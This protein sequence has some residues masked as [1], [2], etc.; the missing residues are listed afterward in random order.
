MRHTQSYFVIMVYGVII[1]MW[2]KWVCGVNR[3]ENF[4]V[5]VLCDMSL[6]CW[7]CLYVKSN[8]DKW[9]YSLIS[10][11]YH[12]ITYLITYFS[13]CWPRIFTMEPINWF[14]M[15]SCCVCDCCKESIN[16]V[17]FSPCCLISFR[18]I[19]NSSS[20]SLSGALRFEARF[21]FFDALLFSA[22]VC[23]TLGLD[24]VLFSPVVSLDSA[25][26]SGALSPLIPAISMIFH[27][28]SCFSAP[29]RLHYWRLLG[30]GIQGSY[31]PHRSRWIS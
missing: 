6:S 1:T 20:L 5:V 24:E 15:A 14:I 27:H 25:T 21:L 11:V 12:L 26:T 10:R 2:C 31:R 22:G 7:W 30:R 4:Q 18:A 17:T 23:G 3:R 16:A 8:G 29:L 19:L 13:F 28:W 9:N